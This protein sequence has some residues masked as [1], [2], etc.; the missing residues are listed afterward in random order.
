[1]FK[2]LANLSIAHQR[3]RVSSLPPAELEA[4]MKRFL[5][6]APENMR[7]FYEPRMKAGKLPTFFVT[8]AHIEM[9]AKRD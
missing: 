1:M 4:L 7:K 9:E 5:E 3:T 6:V 8:W 2:D